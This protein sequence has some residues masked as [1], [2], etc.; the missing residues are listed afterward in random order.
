MSPDAPSILFFPLLFTFFMLQLELSG[1]NLFFFLIAD[2]F[3]FFLNRA[4]NVAMH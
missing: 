2:N 3:F 4:C 1:M